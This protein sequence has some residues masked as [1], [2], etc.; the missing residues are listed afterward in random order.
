MATALIDNELRDHDGE[1]ATAGRSHGRN[2]V[3]CSRLAP[4]R[5]W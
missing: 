2:H 5:C 1:T 4:I 3:D